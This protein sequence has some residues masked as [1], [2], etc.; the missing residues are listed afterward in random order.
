M[1]FLG[2]IAM[3]LRPHAQVEAGV[4]SSRFAAIVAIVD[5]FNVDG[6][7]RVFFPM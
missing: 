3:L 4:A 2:D 5:K 1:Q 7:Q 6:D